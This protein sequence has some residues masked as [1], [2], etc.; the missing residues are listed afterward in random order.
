VLFTNELPVRL[1]SPVSPLWSRYSVIS[2]N[3]S[4]VPSAFTEKYLSWRR[5][6]ERHIT[7]A[8]MIWGAEGAQR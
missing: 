3:V 5:R 2:V 8:P 6:V 7:E 4:S 1:R